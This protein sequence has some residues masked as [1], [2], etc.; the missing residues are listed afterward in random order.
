MKSLK[1]F[2]YC[3]LLLLTLSFGVNAQVINPVKSLVKK[4]DKYF[5]RGSYGVAAEIYLEALEKDE[6]DN[7][8]QLKLAECYR[9]LNQPEDAEYMYR[10][11]MDNSNFIDSQNPIYK[12]YFGLILEQNGKY[13]EAREWFEVYKEK[14]PDDQRVLTKLESIENISIHF[15][16]SSKYEVSVLRL[17][18]YKEDFAPRI[19]RNGV[20]FVSDRRPPYIEDG[21]YNPDS[22]YYR[23]LYFSEILEDGTHASPKLFYPELNSGYHK[24]PIAFYNNE[25]S[26]VYTRSSKSGMSVDKFSMYFVQQAVDKDEWID[27]NAFAFNGKNNNFNVMHPTLNE[28]GTVLYFASDMPGGFGETDIYKSTLDENGKW[29]IPENMGAIINTAESESFPFIT[30]DNKLYFTSNGHGGLGGLDIYEINLSAEQQK[31]VNLGFPI[32]SNKNDFAITFDERGYKGYF[33]S[34]RD[35]GEGG[36]DIYSFT[37]NIYTNGQISDQSS[38]KAIENAYVIFAEKNTG[39]IIGN[40]TDS[41]GKYRAQLDIDGSYIVTIMKDGYITKSGPK[42]STFGS[43]DKIISKDH[44]FNISKEDII[45]KGYVYDKSTGSTV[46]GAFV[47][48]Y[49]SKALKEYIIQTLSDG[50]YIFKLEPENLYTLRIDVPGYF[51]QKTDIDTFEEGKVKFIHDFSMKKVTPNVPLLLENTTYNANKGDI[52]PE[53]EDELDGLAMYLKANP[54]MLVEIRV[55]S[56]GIGSASNNRQITED[57]ASYI[58]YHLIKK[59]VNAL[60]INTAGLGDQY[61]LNNCIEEK[62]CDEA[63]HKINRRV[64]VKFTVVST[65]EETAPPPSNGW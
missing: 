61:L 14:K 4:A 33:S 34:T 3:T 16:D 13:S 32:N 7:E 56:D 43:F 53:T 5:D 47:T 10:H 59:G 60:R 55:H 2:I 51:T 63:E 17:N 20:V 11:F 35:H 46:S 22:V 30:N 57:R 45:S 48:L 15:Q 9:L 36:S 18:S 58:R 42:V 50:S 52:A 24:G 21:I 27:R 40:V 26:L 65:E 37:K 31:V 38:G 1:N 28:Q 12:Y 19:Y 29:S 41:E 23:E 6:D 49:D 44:N 62:D 54:K 8:I 64:E 25:K 39:K